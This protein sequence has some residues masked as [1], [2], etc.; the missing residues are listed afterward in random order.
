M[1]SLEERHKGFM[2]NLSAQIKR[3]HQQKS[4]LEEIA[5]KTQ[6]RQDDLQRIAVDTKAV[7]EL[8][9]I[10]NMNTKTN[11]LLDRYVDST[12]DFESRAK[13]TVNR[14]QEAAGWFT[15]ISQA[16]NSAKANLNAVKQQRV[17]NLFI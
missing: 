7:E 5:E 10:D 14:T 13:E 17:S 6:R 8:D 15:K 16:T 11:Q 9:Q 12:K 4:R 3:S 2:E 1:K